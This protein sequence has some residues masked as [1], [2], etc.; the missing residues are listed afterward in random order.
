MNSS[1]RTKSKSRKRLWIILVVVFCV[2]SGG[3]FVAQSLGSSVPVDPSQL[4]T[5][6]SG[7]V[8]RSIVARGKVQP[9][10]EVEV[11]SMASGIVTKLDADLNQTVHT[12]Q[13][14]TIPE[15]AVIY[16][17]DRKASVWVPDVHG[18]DGH[19]VTGYQD[20][21]FKW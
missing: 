1:T 13:V 8:A 5:A 10:T 11:K 7:V 21:D 6:E 19:R 4:G 12:G 18:K 9:I 20:R 17:K 3:E 16:D 15:Q 14:L 2:L